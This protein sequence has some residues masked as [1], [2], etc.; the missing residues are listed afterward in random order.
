MCEEPTVLENAEKNT[1]WKFYGIHLPG[2]KVNYICDDNFVL[3]PP[4]FSVVCG[5]NGTYTAADSEHP[6]G[7]CVRGYYLVCFCGS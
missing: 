3:N 4:E 6:S 2:T 5:K 7:T 1:E